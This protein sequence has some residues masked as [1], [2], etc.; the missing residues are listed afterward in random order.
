L[1]LPAIPNTWHFQPPK[2]EVHVTTGFYY[3]F[4]LHI[5]LPPFTAFDKKNL[6]KDAWH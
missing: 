4:L 6:P 2:N 1:L 3:G 5:E